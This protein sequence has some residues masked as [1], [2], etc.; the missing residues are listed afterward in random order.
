MWCL[1][2]LLIIFSV[3]EYMSK[4]HFMKKAIKQYKEYAFRHLMK[5]SIHTFQKETTATYISA[6]T[7]DVSSIEANYLENQFRLISSTV[8]FVGALIMMLLY[9]PLLTLVAALLIILPIIASLVVGNRMEKA[10]LEVSKRNASLL[11]FSAFA[12]S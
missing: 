10:E 5:K 3:L 2:L 1:L 6:L 4:P 12:R 8:L 7:N 11:Q 9:S